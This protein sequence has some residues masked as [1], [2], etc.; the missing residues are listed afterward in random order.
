VT[1][2]FSNWKDGTLSFKKHE[3]SSCHREAVE[4]MITLPATTCNVSELLSKQHAIQKIKNRDALF[5][6]MSSIKYLCR[7]G[8][9][10]RGDNEDGNLTQLLLKLNR[11]QI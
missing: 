10:L 3:K 9:A 1:R 5:E 6:I 8:L 2:G 7:Q 4:V 11:I